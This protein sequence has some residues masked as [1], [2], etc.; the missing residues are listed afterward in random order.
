MGGHDFAVM[1][2]RGQV[3]GH[4]PGCREHIVVLPGRR[5]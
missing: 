1:Q 3:L 5:L 4:L 2:V